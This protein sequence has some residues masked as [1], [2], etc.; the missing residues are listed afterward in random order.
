MIELK[1]K[2]GLEIKF[3]PDTFSLIFGDEVKKV[4]PAI[5]TIDQMR[6]VLVD[7]SLTEPKELYFMYRD[8]YRLGDEEKIRKHQLRFDITVIKPDKLGKELMKTAGH[9]HQ[10]SFPEL[11]E[12]VYG[13]AICL[14]QRLDDKDDK[15]INDVFAVH[16]KQGQKIFC[17]PNYGHILINP[18]PLPLI[19][20]NWVSAQFQ[21]QYEK[22]QQAKGA[23]YYV[24][25]NN[26]NLRWEKNSFF[27]QV[28]DIH[29]TF[30]KDEI[31]GFG[32]SSNRPMYTLVDDLE[33]I[34]FL[35]NPTKFRYDSVFKG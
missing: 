26:G 23:C 18:G 1:D 22:Y 30:P 3:D 15:K 14:L 29:F 21:S 35:N 5:R 28:R 27:T 33:K 12:V 19:T 24:F 2:L 4:K 7:P 11:Y 9:Y 25:E 34:S 16:A 20:S 17:L 31:K 13:R 6:D 10:G 32:L 8:V